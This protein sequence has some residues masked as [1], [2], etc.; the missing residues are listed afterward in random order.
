MPLLASI[1]NSRLFLKKVWL[2]RFALPTGGAIGKLYS[3]SSRGALRSVTSYKFKVSAFGEPPEKTPAA[4]FRVRSRPIP[5]RLD[6][7]FGAARTF[8]AEMRDPPRL[9]AG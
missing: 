5:M 7:K 9:V 8:V 4:R 3:A 1:V 6:G 2:M